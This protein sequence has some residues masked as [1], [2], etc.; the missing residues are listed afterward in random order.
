MNLVKLHNTKLI[1][2]NLLHLYALTEISE[3]DTKETTIFMEN[4]NKRMC[5]Q[6]KQMD[7]YTVFFILEDLI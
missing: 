3:K 5:R 1:D 2:R 4:V 7:R 6:Q